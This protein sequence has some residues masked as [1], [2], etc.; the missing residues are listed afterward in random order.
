MSFF[1]EL[2]RRNVFRVAAAYLV[3]AWLLIEVSSTLEE[4]LRLPEWADSLLAMFLLLGFPVALFF[5]WAFEI[6]PDGIRRESG[7]KVDDASRALTA[8]RLNWAVIALVSLAL[9]LV[10]VDR[11][12]PDRESVGTG[13]ADPPQVEAAVQEAE[14]AAD[15]APVT[16]IEPLSIAVLPFVN[17]SS[18]PEQEY[19]SD[20]LTEELLNLLAAVA[21]LKV[22]ARTSSF[23]Y[24][25]KLETI[26]LHE[27]ARQLEVAHVLEGSVRRSGDRIRITA[28]LIKAE[29]GFHLWSRTWDRTLDDIFAIQDE[30]AAAV[31]EE[32]RIT[33]LGPAPHAQSVDPESFE[34]AMHGRF[35]F[36]RRDGGDLAKALELFED[37]VAI[38]PGNAVA[39]VGLAP[40][41][42]WLFD[43]PDLERSR[44]AAENAVRLDPDNP[45]ARIRLATALWMQG[46]QEGHRRESRRAWELGQNNALVLATF[47]GRYLYVGNVDKA[48]ELYQRAVAADPLHLINLSNLAE[49]LADANRLP[50]AEATILRALELAPGSYGAIVSLAGV[51]LRQERY[52]ETLELIRQLPDDFPNPGNEGRKL[53]LLAMAEHATGNPVASDAAL[54]E[55]VRQF[56]NTQPVDVAALYAWRGE[57]DLA[58]GILEPLFEDQLDQL[59]MDLFLSPNFE[60]LHQDPRWDALMARFESRPKNSEDW[61]F[62]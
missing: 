41:Y 12:S 62:D 35:L 40:L 37:A 61:F 34:L 30:I 31:T 29:D 56:G 19:F 18:D 59:P 21:E 22:A 9:V 32:L 60:N 42:A 44:T 3:G 53:Q 48:L 16:G 38:D 2:R 14:P 36:N 5:S 17:L 47:S 1:R 10:V 15:D 25:G 46:D 11:W 27:I 51:R 7:A 6:T 23:F 45:E 26:P 13:A 24:K 8:R 54:A 58:F 52:Q 28:Q 33:L 50:E 55:F 4:T 43:P 20:G 39:W 49:I 57:A